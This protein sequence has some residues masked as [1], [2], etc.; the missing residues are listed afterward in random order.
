MFRGLSKYKLVYSHVWNT[1]GQSR[2][3]QISFVLQIIARICRLI[4]LPIAISLIIANLSKR[5]F[6]TAQ[7][8]VFLYACFSFVLG[9]LTPLIKYIGM[10][11]EN[12]AYREIT[13]N[14][15]SRLIAADLDYFHSNLA[16][17]LT[18]A[19]RQY[20]D[21]CM[22]FARALRDRYL[23]T[24][25]SIVFPLGVILYLDIPIGLVAFAL[26]VTQAVYLLWASHTITPYRTRSREIYKRNS[27]RMADI[28]SNILAVKST[29]Q[30]EIRAK[31]VRQGSEDEGRLFY[32]RYIMQTK[33][34]A[35]REAITV[36]FFLVLLWLTVHRM[37]GGHIS[38][39]AAVLVVTY[40][41]TI[42]TGIYQLSDDLDEHDDLVDKI[43]PA[44]EILNRKNVVTDP[45]R[46]KVLKKVRG[47]VTFKDISFSYDKNEG[48]TPVLTGFSL[49]IPAGQKVGIV[50]L[51]GAGKSTLAK[52]L[53]RFNDV[54]A[55]QVSIDGIDIRTLKQTDVRKHIAYIPQEPLL[56]HASIRDN[57]ILSRPN[58]TDKEI[59]E[60]LSS[61]HALKFVDQLPG[62][63]DSIVGE[64]GVK[65]SGGQKQRIAIAR[66]VLQHSPIMVLDEAT[67][68]LD[69]E[70]EQIIKDSFTDVLKG[71]TAIVI[72]HR[73]STLS[74]M[75]RIIVIEKGVCVED[76]PHAK[77]L[78]QNG[79]YA[80]LW[81]HQL[82]HDED[83]SILS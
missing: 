17:Y 33:L 54:D 65:L 69:S 10:L 14:Y 36:A 9:A 83:L 28:V 50:G 38:I 8:A 11:G 73:L 16:G 12:K 46:P 63:L 40:T 48:V 81:K 45:P 64:R 76:G 60:A 67:S 7:N 79:L 18:T 26:S 74:E 43:I 30:E 75:D 22:Q 61:A 44:F 51:S 39:T 34:I 13:G 70:S 41:T 5:N 15:F 35:L 57:V 19:T 6:G 21:S 1:Y 80:R 71:K 82:R 20:V 62:G 47:Q 68:A 55:G 4:I 78:K 27:G 52:L 24:I 72:A 66:A 77:L 29:A 56:F 59:R 23:N 25:L 49:S 53:L 37:S 31:Q 2:T 3:V 32:E 42:L 58:A